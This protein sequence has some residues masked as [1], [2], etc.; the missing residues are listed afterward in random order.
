MILTT[1]ETSLYES[2]SKVAECF[3]ESKMYRSPAF[4][5]KSKVAECF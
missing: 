4:E 5:D 2:T 1:Q 3:A